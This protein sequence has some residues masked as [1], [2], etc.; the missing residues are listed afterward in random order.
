MNVLFI[1]NVCVGFMVSEIPRV[2]VLG[3][4]PTGTFRIRLLSP[5]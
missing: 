1:K 5:M 4:C 2:Y 3:Q